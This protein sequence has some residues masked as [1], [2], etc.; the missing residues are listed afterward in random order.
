MVV[1]R[2]F[3][4]AQETRTWRSGFI[5]RT[6][7][8]QYTGDANYAVTLPAAETTASLTVNQAATTTALSSGQRKRLALLTALLEDR[9]IYVLDEW[10][11]VAERS[12]G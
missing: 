5:A 12:G 1:P 8:A 7:A 6:I 9:P 4:A 10:A 11:A 2:Y 3:E